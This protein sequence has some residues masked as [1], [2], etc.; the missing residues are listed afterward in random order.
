MPLKMFKILVGIW[1]YKKDPNKTSCLE[2]SVTRLEKYL[3]EPNN[4]SQWYLFI[5]Q[6]NI[7][8]FNKLSSFKDFFTL[9]NIIT[10]Y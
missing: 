10:N 1:F 8:S 6:K 3:I 9:L 4:I 2:Y 7:I 5:V